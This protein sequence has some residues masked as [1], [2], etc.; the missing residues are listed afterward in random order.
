MGIL[1]QRS[2]LVP[3]YLLGEHVR[4]FAFCIHRLPTTFAALQIVAFLDLLVLSS[5]YFLSVSLVYDIYSLLSC[6]FL[7]NSSV[8][9]RLEIKKEGTAGESLCFRDDWQPG[10]DAG[11]LRRRC[12][13]LRPI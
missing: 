6:L 1:E 10:Y 11:V 5:S 4:L 2:C 7:H 9:C 13:R 8:R 3:A 12:G